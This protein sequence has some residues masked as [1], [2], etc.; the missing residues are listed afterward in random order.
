VA[1]LVD[2]GAANGVEWG[3]VMTK[4]LGFASALVTTLACACSSSSTHPQTTKGDASVAE[5]GG[6]EGP[7]PVL[8]AV[9]DACPALQT[10]TMSIDGASVKLWVGQR[11]ADQKGSILLYWHGTGSAADEVGAFM[12][13]AA[14]PI[15]DEITAEGGVVASFETTNG[16]GDNTG[17][18]VWYTGDYD[19]ADIIVACA[20]QQLNID[21][22]RIYAAGCSAGGLEAGTAAILRSSYLA[23]VVPNSGGHILPG[24]IAFQDPNHIP[25]V[26]T[27]HGT[28]AN[29]V[30]GIH[31]IDWSKA[32][33]RQII[34]SGGQAV[35]CTTPN[36]HC[37]ILFHPEVISPDL[38]VAAQ[39]QFL[40][41]HP[42]GQTTNPYANGLPSV[43]PSFC[44]Q[45][46]VGGDQ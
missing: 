17:N 36:G 14:N 7:V 37:M 35:D 15:V 33:D 5:G 46:T 19:V 10:G 13:T 1:R 3:L 8:P 34:G 28:Y 40:K 44:A 24:S 22:R 20:A 38:V 32:L 30:V 6:K 29:D 45:V 18:N 4:N 31:F 26:M 2:G 41:D 39:W 12:N 21:T 9:P 42:F 27:T 43:Y 11:Q 23:A 25:A 16:K